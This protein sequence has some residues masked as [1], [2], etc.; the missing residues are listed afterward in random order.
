M[1]LTAELR[2]CVNLH[3]CYTNRIEMKAVEIITRVKAGV[4]RSAGPRGKQF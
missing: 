3:T 4:D 2:L 1:N